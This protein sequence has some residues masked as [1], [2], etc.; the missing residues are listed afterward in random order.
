LLNFLKKAEQIYFVLGLRCATVLLQIILIMF[1]NIG[2]HY[3]LPFISLFSVIIAEIIFTLLSFYYYYK[4]RPYHSLKKNI[5]QYALFG[6]VCADVLFLVLLLYFSGGAT[7]AFVSLL[8]IPIA[9]AAVTLSPFLLLLVTSFAIASYSF[10]LWLLPM[11]VMHGNMQGHF[12]GMWINFLFSTMVVAVVVGKMTRSI[13][14]QSLALS[15]YRESV[16][17]QEQ[18]IA[19]GVA[20]AQVTHQLAT[21]IATVQLLADELSDDFPQ[22]DVIIDMQK[23]LTRCRESLQ[24]FRHLTFDIKQQTQSVITGLTLVDNIQDYIT[25]NYP[26]IKLTIHYA[27]NE[28]APSGLIKAKIT[29]DASLLPAVLNLLNNAIRATEENGSDVIYLQCQL[30]DESFQLLIRDFGLGFT[31]DKLNELGMH[32]VESEEGLGMAVFLSY[33]SLEKLGGRL[34]LSN[35]PEG[36]ALVNLNLPL[37]K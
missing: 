12:I 2:L 28:Q 27:D 31:D 18:I 29:S 25:L 33:T 6:Q 10:L 37:A 36:G 15:V 24:E 8:L 3:Q 26:H 16:L 1:V 23:Q 4:L 34:L 9:I 32:T 35:H 14:Q 11:S 7:N 22:N 20:S 5:K 13:Q 19:L 17:K 30:V 21:P